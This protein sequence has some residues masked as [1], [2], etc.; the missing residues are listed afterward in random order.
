MTKVWALVWGVLVLCPALSAE[1]PYGRIDTYMRAAEAQ[2]FSGAVLVSKQDDPTFVKGYG[3][4]NRKQ[5]FAHNA[6]TVID[7]G[8]NTKQFTAAAT[9][10]LVEDDKL[11]LTDTLRQFFTG[12]PEDKAGI[13]IHQLLS[14]TSGLVDSVGRDRE[15]VD[16]A[17]LLRRAFDAELVSKPGQAL[18]YSNVGYSLL[19]AIIERVSDQP[20]ETYLYEKL[21]RPAGLEHTG[22]LRPDWQQNASQLAM[23]YRSTLQD[24]G[25]TTAMYQLQGVT[26]HL[27][28]NGGLNS[29][30][31]DMHRWLRQLFNQK[32]L[33]A[34]STAMLFARQFSPEHDSPRYGGYGWFSST[35]RYGE[36]MISHNGAN[37]VFQSSIRWF[38]ARD[39]LILTYSNAE[40]SEVERVAGVIADMLLERDAS[41]APLQMSPYQAVWRFSQHHQP[42][43]S[44]ELLPY[45]AKQTSLTFDLK[46]LLNRTGSY[47]LSQQQNDWA[48]ALFKLNVQQFPDDGNLWDSLGEG[49]LRAGQLEHAKK[50]FNKAIVLGDNVRC[51]WCSNSRSRLDEI[52][53]RLKKP[54]GTTD[55]TELNSTP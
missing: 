46:V 14:H 12:V 52:E 13:T 47:F 23:G 53:R 2:G 4:A 43:Q 24:V 28:G 10:N 45:I 15:Y 27:V 29:T 17:T 51:Y 1:E 40:Y 49:Q 11:R 21:L 48:L 35:E 7:I 36:Q 55:L 50:S 25:S 37:G 9:L 16:K 20:Y 6:Q 30:L 19:A 38:P 8:S 34:D 18:N 41:P 5:K 44:D 31:N 54:S 26:W 39:T 22:Y 32:A 42:A 33:S 3:L